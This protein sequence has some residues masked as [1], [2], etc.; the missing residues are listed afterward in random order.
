M[1]SQVITLILKTDATHDELE[2]LMRE[3]LHV[4]SDD[5]MPRTIEVDQV[6]IGTV[7]Q[8]KSIEPATEMSQSGPQVRMSVYSHCPHCNTP[9]GELHKG[10]CPFSNGYR[11]T[12][13]VG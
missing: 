13:K 4:R 9:I 3:D 12:G 8:T 5:G 10:D 11:F 6:M 2:A 7:D 1:K